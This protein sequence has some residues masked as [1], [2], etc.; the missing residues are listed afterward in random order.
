MWKRWGEREREKYSSPFSFT[1]LLRSKVRS[2]TSPIPWCPRERWPGQERPSDLTLDSHDVTLRV[3]SFGCKLTFLSS[4]DR[5]LTTQHTALVWWSIYNTHTAWRNVERKAWFSTIKLNQN[6]KIQRTKTV[7][8][9]LR[10]RS[11]SLQT[12]S[13]IHYVTCLHI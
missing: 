3:I 11:C 4:V 2:S 7:I 1:L 12:G 5:G 10:P 8:E 9:Q 13:R 6:S